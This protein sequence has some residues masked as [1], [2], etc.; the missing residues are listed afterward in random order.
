MAEEEEGLDV[1]NMR[2]TCSMN[3]LGFQRSKWGKQTIRTAWG[4]SE[5][6]GIFIDLGFGFDCRLWELECMAW[7]VRVF[8]S[9]II[10]CVFGY[11]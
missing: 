11:L 5:L 6:L 1:I 10:V 3:E 9:L 7:H 2:F 4:M 8:L